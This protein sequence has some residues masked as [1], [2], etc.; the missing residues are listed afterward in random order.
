MAA[1]AAIVPSPGYPVAAL[2]HDDQGCGCGV[3]FN[4]AGKRER[5]L[6]PHREP[7]SK[8]SSERQKPAD[9]PAEDV[10]LLIGQGSELELDDERLRVK[11]GEHCYFCRDATAGARA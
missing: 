3:T 6:R 2:I 9:E 5:A 10:E 7:T 8:A 4:E 11:V 1:K